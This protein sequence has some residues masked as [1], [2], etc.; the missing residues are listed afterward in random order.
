MRKHLIFRIWETRFAVDVGKVVE[1]MNPV[2]LDP[3]PEMPD[4]VVGLKDVR[5]EMIPIVDMR[6]R[7]GVAPSTKRDRMFTINV[8]GDKV[9]LIVDDVLGVQLIDTDD[10]RRPPVLFRGLKKKFMEGLCGQKDE[11][12]VLLNIEKILTL[13][14]AIAL[15][16]ARKVKA[17]K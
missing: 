5:G 15:R 2:G 9:G 6:D 4:F 14:E 11:V 1:V 10:V 3:I 7:M 12:I 8:D 17:A 16:V 13:D